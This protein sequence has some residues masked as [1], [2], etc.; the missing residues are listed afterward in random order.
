MD[1][2]RTRHREGE[3]LAQLTRCASWLSLAAAALLAGA[4]LSGC[5]RAAP[6]APGATTEAADDAEAIQAQQAAA[7]LAALGGAANAEQRALYEG[8]F[9]ASGALGDVALGEGAWE[10][11]LLSDYAQFVRPG[12]GQDGG[13]PDAR[14]FHEK[15]VRVVAGPLTITIRHEACELPNGVHTDYNANVLFEGVSYQGCAERGVSNRPRAT[16]AS[17]VAD[18]VPA[19][20]ACL[21]RATAPPA[22]V[23]IASALDEDVVSVRMRQANGRRDECLVS[24]D[25]QRVDAFEPVADM[26]R[27]S[28][29]GD[30]EFVRAPGPPPR[31]QPCRGV[32]PVDAPNGARLGW[33]VK[34]TC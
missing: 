5:N 24:S 32:E 19:I 10:L 6:D 8:D 26:D 3:T 27:R 7:Q 34:R 14:D 4:A 21:A 17:V 25:G 1:L 16:W 31:E 20:D 22:V 15:G 11:Q 33:L 30:P 12:L 28:G 2:A 18:L 13:L 23:T 9:Q 29:E